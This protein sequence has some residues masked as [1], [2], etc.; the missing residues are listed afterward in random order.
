MMWM[1]FLFAFYS[2]E[3]W[4]LSKQTGTQS[5]IRLTTFSP[6]VR[7]PPTSDTCRPPVRFLLCCMRHWVAPSASSLPR[8]TLPSCSQPM[9][10]HWGC[11]A[12]SAQSAAPECPG[13]VLGIPLAQPTLRL[14][15]LLPLYSLPQPQVKGVRLWLVGRLCASS[16]HSSYPSHSFSSCTSILSQGLRPGG[17]TLPLLTY[18]QYRDLC[19]TC[20]A[21][22]LL[23]KP[24]SYLEQNIC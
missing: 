3:N 14:R 7:D 20:L 24:I 15:D 23:L 12:I 6:Y 18:C 22:G 13:S 5:Q 16:C 2:L 11:W 17:P 4:G 8:L 21:I 10:E 9:T 1:L 19:C